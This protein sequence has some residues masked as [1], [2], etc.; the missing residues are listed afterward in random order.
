[1]ELG[2]SHAIYRK[3]KMG[4]PEY[5]RFNFVKAIASASRTLSVIRW[6]DGSSIGAAKSSI[7]SITRDGAC[8]VEDIVKKGPDF[9]DS[10]SGVVHCPYDERGLLRWGTPSGWGRYYNGYTGGWDE[11]DEFEGSDGEY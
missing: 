2:S 1:M 7:Y 5:K 6:K 10:D 9:G 8:E 3:S 11:H 4:H